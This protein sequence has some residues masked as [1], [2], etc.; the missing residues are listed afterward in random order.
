MVVIGHNTQRVAATKAEEGV[1]N[2]GAQLHK[3]P[4]LE[5]GVMDDKVWVAHYNVWMIVDIREDFLKMA[6]T[7]LPKH[8]LLP[9]NH[10]I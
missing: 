8:N 10:K 2:A 6:Q 7:L 5:E 4:P 1:A 3:V 9:L